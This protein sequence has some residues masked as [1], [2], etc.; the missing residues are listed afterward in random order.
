MRSGL[1]IRSLTKR[2]AG[3]CYVKSQ[4]PN[5]KLEHLVKMYTVGATSYAC[6]AR[7]PRT[8]ECF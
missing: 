5:L 8:A 1:P 7:N 6:T 2:G 4:W 3:L